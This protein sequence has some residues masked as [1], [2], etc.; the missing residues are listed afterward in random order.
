[1][2]RGNAWSVGNTKTLQTMVG[3]TETVFF[4]AVTV[5]SGVGTRVN[6][7]NT[8]VLVSS[9]MVFGIEK[10]FSILDHSFV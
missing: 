6:V 5:V 4:A 7:S 8:M 1:V 3:V 2:K 9:T 10:M